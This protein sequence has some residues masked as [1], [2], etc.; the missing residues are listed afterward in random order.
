[1]TIALTNT[2]GKMAIETIVF[3]LTKQTKKHHYFYY[4]GKHLGNYKE[5]AAWCD[6]KCMHCF[7]ALGVLDL[8]VTEHPL[9]N[10]N[11]PICKMW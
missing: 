6:G 7:E 11:F 5:K 10:L 2:L 4:L 9:K 1:M 3:L 8:K